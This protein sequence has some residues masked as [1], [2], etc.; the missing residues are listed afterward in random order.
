[1]VR[2]HEDEVESTLNELLLKILDP[3]RRDQLEGKP[4]SPFQVV[5]DRFPYRV[6]LALLELRNNAEHIF[7][8]LSVGGING[9]SRGGTGGDHQ[10][11]YKAYAYLMA[12]HLNHT[13][14]IAY[15]SAVRLKRRLCGVSFCTADSR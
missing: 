3:E 1:M 13:E 11:R 7:F 15:F 14:I 4:C 9:P 2:V 10:E 6:E 12:A 8:L 5:D